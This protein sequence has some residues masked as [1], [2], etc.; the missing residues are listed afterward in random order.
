MPCVAD[1]DG[2]QCGDDGCGGT[3]GTCG[4]DEVTTELLACVDG[5]CVPGCTPTPV[6]C[7][8]RSC[9]DDG[10]GGSC[11]TCPNNTTCSADGRCVIDPGASCFGRCGVDAPA[12]CGCDISCLDFF[13]CCPDFVSQC[14]CV[15]S[16]EGRVCGDD[17]C[18]GSCGPCGGATPF[19]GN[20][21]Q[22]RSTCEPQC[23]G[24]ECGDDGCG[25]TC[26]TCTSGES[27]NDSDRCVPAAWY[28]PDHYYGDAAHCDCSCGA[29]DPDCERIGLTTGCPFGAAC[30]DETGLCDVSFC[31]SDD[32]CGSPALCIGRYASGSGALDGVCRSP[33]P[34]GLAVNAL[35]A[36]DAGCSTEVC[37]AGSCRRH[38]RNDDDCLGAEVC[39]G[40]AVVQ[41]LTGDPIGVLG[42][43]DSR[44][45]IGATCA[46][47]DEC[48][49]LLCLALVDPIDQ[50]PL[51]RC[52]EPLGGAM[53]GVPCDPA[54]PCALGLVCADGICE[55]P[56]PGGQADCPAGFVCGDHPLYPAHATDP[57]GSPLIKVCEPL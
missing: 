30:V 54:I 57:Q 35:C 53:A 38:C 40:V 48:G 52:G 50:T 14:A 5:A 22:C 47:Q 44:S 11:G 27:C 8:T 43:C 34:A 28:C 45:S 4:F 56:C 32:D 17:G 37:A 19:C 24:R 46:S 16:C 39:I 12:G 36:S 29:P 21:G 20:D 13:D 1:C 9:G 42:V 26:G 55:R 31:T 15:G 23:D 41:P 18:G 2:R 33:G 25:G 7:E 6:L 10:C 49:E 51:Y 3:C